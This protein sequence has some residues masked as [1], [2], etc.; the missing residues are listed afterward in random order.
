MP[1]EQP[2]DFDEIPDTQPFSKIRAR[3]LDPELRVTRELWDAMARFEEGGGKR[4]PV[5]KRLGFV[6]SLLLAKM[7]DFEQE[8]VD[9]RKRVTEL[10]G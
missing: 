3:D 4:L 1:D 8:V 9:L 6:V 5:E 10:G 7:K 2:E